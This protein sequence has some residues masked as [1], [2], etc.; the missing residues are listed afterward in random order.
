M[1]AR[2]PWPDEQKNPDPR[3]DLDRELEVSLWPTPFTRRVYAEDVEPGA[4]SWWHG[5]EEATDSVLRGMGL[6]SVDQLA[7]GGGV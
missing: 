2:L 1:V 7:G 5:E 4:P 6:K 3:G